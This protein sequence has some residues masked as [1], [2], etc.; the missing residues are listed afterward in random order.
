MLQ[1]SGWERN[2]SKD[3]CSRKRIPPDRSCFAL[4]AWAFHVRIG[5][6]SGATFFQASCVD[7]CNTLRQL[8]ECQR[9]MLFFGT[10]A[11]LC[12]LTNIFRGK[13]GRMVC[14]TL[15][16]TASSL[17]RPFGLCLASF[18]L[19]GSGGAVLTGQLGLVGELAPILWLGKGCRGPLVSN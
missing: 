7:F 4:L 5:L 8:C 18:L 13:L 3:P 9:H 15:P 16:E 1:R 17:L 19:R 12:R 10:S 11:N 14:V 6:C 2:D